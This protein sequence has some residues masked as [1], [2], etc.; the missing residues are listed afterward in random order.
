MA[1]AV[2]ALIHLLL[3]GMWASGETF[4]WPFLGLDFVPGIQPYWE[5]FLGRELNLATIA[6]ELAGIVYLAA[7]WVIT[8]MSH[9]ENRQ[10]FLETG[11]LAG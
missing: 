6:Q 1:V 8:G 5:G 11:R 2:G 10:T 3:D 7:L 9:P 4:L